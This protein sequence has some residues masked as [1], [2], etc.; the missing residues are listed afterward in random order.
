MIP[1]NLSQSN[2]LRSE[3]RDST[4]RHIKYMEK[5][6]GRTCRKIWRTAYYDRNEAFTFAS[7]TLNRKDRLIVTLEAYVPYVG[8]IVSH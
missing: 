8:W 1:N 2:V 3:L 6:L 7:F 4:K 5:H